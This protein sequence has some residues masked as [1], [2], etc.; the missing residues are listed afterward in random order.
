MQ[1]GMARQAIGWSCPSRCSNTPYIFNKGI[2]MTLKSLSVAACMVLL[3]GSSLNM[4]SGIP[5]PPSSDIRD[6]ARTA[7]SAFRSCTTQAETT[8]VVSRSKGTN[9]QVAVS[10]CRADNLSTYS[11]CINLLPGLV[12]P[13]DAN[14]KTTKKTAVTSPSTTNT[15]RSVTTPKQ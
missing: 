7:C 12:K 3:S 6:C 14:A 8:L 1:S 5:T 2:L 10:D 11:S 15:Q 13:T 9:T 4:V